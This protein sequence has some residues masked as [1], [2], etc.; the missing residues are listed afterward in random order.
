MKEKLRD[1]R[2]KSALTQEDLA[3]EIHV[4]RQ[5]ISSWE[6]GKSLPDLENI[7]LLA[8]YYEISPQVFLGDTNSPQHKINTDLE[9]FFFFLILVA[10]CIPVTSFIIV[11]LLLESKKKISAKFY[12]PLLGFFI[13]MAVINLIA[14]FVLDLFILR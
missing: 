7:Q 8:D 12:K 13:L 2:K 1:L 10:C 4:S 6:T 11:F 14:F 3:Q 5:T 9:K